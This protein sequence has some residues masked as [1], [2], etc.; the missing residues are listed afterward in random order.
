MITNQNFN[1]FEKI[2]LEEYRIVRRRIVEAIL[3]T[4]MATHGKHLT[5]LKAKLEALS[6]NNG[7]NLELMVGGD[8]LGKNYDSQQLV[9]NMIVHSSDVSNPAKP[10]AV[11]KN[12]VDLVFNEFFT[13]G[14][15]EK[16]NK[17]PVS[18]L[19]DRECTNISKSQLGFIN[20][21]VLPTF[22][23][24]LMMIPEI[25]KYMDNIKSNYKYYEE[26][27]NSNNKE[28]NR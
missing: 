20:F 15:L 5:Q 4:D 17:L 2:T 3:S 24:I 8:N 21:I 25:S 10:L 22:D 13:Q 23:C 26:L 28:E 16:S 12:W 7:K 19:C 27:I 11:Y 6:I 9:L 18:V 14:D 1:I